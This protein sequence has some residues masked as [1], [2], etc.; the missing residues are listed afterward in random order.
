MVKFFGHKK[1]VLR[2]T[3][4]PRA[5]YTREHCRDSFTRDAVW[6]NP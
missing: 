3:V 1:S 2:G 6:E 5:K 4:V